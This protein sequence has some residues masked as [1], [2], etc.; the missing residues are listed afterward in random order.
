MKA[1]EQEE[2][3]TFDFGDGPVRAHQHKNPDGSMGGW[4]A[5]TATV[6][7]TAYIGED[8]K[9]SDNAVVADDAQVFGIWWCPGVW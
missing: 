8:A 5:N 1:E 4:V 2:L 9:V 6:K 7:G 3:I